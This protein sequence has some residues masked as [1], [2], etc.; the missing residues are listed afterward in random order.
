MVG[1]D[2]AITTLDLAGATTG[3]TIVLRASGVWV[4]S[5]LAGGGGAPSTATYIT[6]TADATLSAEQ[7]LGSLA[8]GMMASATTTGVVT[9]RTLTGTAGAV[10]VTNGDGSGGNPTFSL[11]SSVTVPSSYSIGGDPADIGVI[12]LENNTTIAWEASPTGTDVTLKVDASE[13]MQASGAFN[14]TAVSE[15][16]VD[17]TNV[18][19]N[20][21]IFAPTT[22]AQLAGVLSNEVG[23]DGGFLRVEAT[24]ASAGNTFVRRASGVW[25]DSTLAG[26]SGADTTKW[27]YQSKPNGGLTTIGDKLHVKFVG[28]GVYPVA[29]ADTIN[30]NVLNLK[31]QAAMFD[32]FCGG[33]A[34]TG[35]IGN[36]GWSL[37]N[38]GST[39]DAGQTGYATTSSPCWFQIQ[40]NVGAANNRGQIFLASQTAM[41][42]G[43]NMRLTARIK[44]AEASAGT[45]FRFGFYDLASSAVSYPI[46]GLFVEANID[47]STNWRLV[48][49]NGST[50]TFDNSATAVTTSITT[51]DIVTNSGYTQADMYI[52]GVL[53]TGSITTNLPG[54]TAEGSIHFVEQTKDASTRTVG[55]DFFSYS[56]TGISR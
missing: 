48:S 29:N 43:G 7:A 8:T 18:N 36:L 51:I 46:D 4:D 16:G 2:T 37:S 41:V 30:I 11:P 23:T 28:A 22:S 24:G 32:D 26:G 20:L 40:N 49:S 47:S 39:F 27:Y 14:A 25:V 3:N 38:T 53:T 34:T 42:M 52:N 17:V 21:G 56:L 15:G 5:T 54:S 9:T 10:S 44:L 1:I 35:N 19:D 12:N 13:I 6:Q 31:A 33:L 45:I 55:I 50:R